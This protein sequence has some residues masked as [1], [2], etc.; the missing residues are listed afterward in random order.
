MDSGAAP[1]APFSSFF[2]VR[3]TRSGFLGAFAKVDIPRGTLVLDEKPLFTLDAPLQ[4]YLFQRAQS[5]KGSGPTPV[6]GEEEEEPAKTL[7][8][9]LDRAIRTQLSWKTD[10]Q[11]AQFWDLANT[12]AELPPAMGIF[13]TNAVQCVFLSPLSALLTL[14][15][16][17]TCSTDAL[18][19]TGRKTKPAVSSSS[20][21][22]STPPAVRPSPALAGTPQPAR[23]SSTPTATSR[24][25]KRSLGRTSTSSSSLPASRSA[26]LR[27]CEFSSSSARATRARTLK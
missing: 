10:E 14:F 27:C 8:E 3:P 24:S 4:A 20:F 11:R 15:K 5:G 12:R 26:K 23:P 2:D 19:L 25:V 6:E 13:A 18:R 17:T 1:L 9:F 22:A 16:L 7:D 21:P